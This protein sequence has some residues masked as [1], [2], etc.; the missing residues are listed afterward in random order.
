MGTGSGAA[1][2]RQEPGPAAQAEAAESER[3]DQQANE[4][5]TLFDLGTPESEAGETPAAAGGEDREAEKNEA[6][7]AV[8]E[9]FTGGSRADPDDLTVL[10]GVGP[11]TQRL[12]NAMNVFTYRQ[13]AS[14]TAEDTE[15]VAVAI[16]WT[17]DRIERNNWIEDARAHHLRIHGEET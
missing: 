2:S 10:T 13:I 1:E 15:N 12:L 3:G 16:G 7:R 14:F 17:P 6:R 9:R 4:G 11:M 5:S 8:V